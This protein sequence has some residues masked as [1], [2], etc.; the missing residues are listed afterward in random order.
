MQR[1]VTRAVRDQSGHLPAR[2]EQT[3]MGRNI[4]A[5]KPGLA[6][7]VGPVWVSFWNKGPRANIALCKTTPADLYWKEMSKIGMNTV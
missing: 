6:A 3:N 5:D 7:E 4:Q 1:V 2:R